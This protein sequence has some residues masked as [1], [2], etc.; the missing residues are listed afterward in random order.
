[1]ARSSP[2]GRWSGVVALA[3]YN[4]DGS[5]DT[6]FGNGG[7]VTTDTFGSGGESGHQAA[8]QAD[9]K[10]VV[11]GYTSNGSNNDFLVLRYN[12]NGSPDTGFGS[13]GFGV[14]PHP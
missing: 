14:L 2:L 8:L 6:G 1:M 12:S 3:R 9:G 4:T 11:A 10:I 5:L 7:T 13:G